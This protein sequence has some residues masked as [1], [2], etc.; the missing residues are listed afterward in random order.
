MPGGT[1]RQ[2]T[3]VR[4]AE[5]YESSIY[6]RGVGADDARGLLQVFGGQGRGDL[7]YPGEQDA[8]PDSFGSLFRVQAETDRYPK[9]QF[10]AGHKTGAHRHS[11]LHSTLGCAAGAGNRA[12][13]T[14]PLEPHGMAGGS[15]DSGAGCLL[16]AGAK[17]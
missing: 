13:F 7:Y 11:D 2:H 10:Y 3:V 9:A 8:L 1:G 15:C 12:V 6:K 14:A 17:L 16:A 4:G 5:D